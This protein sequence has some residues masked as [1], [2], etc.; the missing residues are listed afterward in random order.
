MGDGGRASSF[1]GNIPR[2]QNTPVPMHGAHS[3]PQV[4]Y[5][6]CFLHSNASLSLVDLQPCGAGDWA[7]LGFTIMGVLC[8]Q[9]SGNMMLPTMLPPA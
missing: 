1:R 5:H 3:T 6:V 9:V 2:Y 7:Q 8:Q 4:S